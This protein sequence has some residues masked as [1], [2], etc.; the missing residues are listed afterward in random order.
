V[1]PDSRQVGSNNFRL[2]EDGEL[3]IVLLKLVEYLGHS[4]PIVS[5][6][7]YNEVSNA[8]RACRSRVID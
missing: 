4:N 7:A 3:N 5:N 8:S 1:R 2:L 6:A